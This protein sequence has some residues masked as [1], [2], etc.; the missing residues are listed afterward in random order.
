M[1]PVKGDG[2]LSRFA[3][4]LRNL[5]M[6]TGGT[7][8]L[9]EKYGAS[10]TAVYEALAGK[11]LPTSETLE[12][13]VIA[14]GAEDESI[15]W[16][17]QRLETETALEAEA[18]L[19]GE[20]KIKKTPEE[21]KFQEALTTLWGEVGHPSRNLWGDAAELSPRTVASYLDGSTLP[22]PG[23]YDQ[24]IRG[25]AALCGDDDAL[26][27]WVWEQ[28][29]TLREEHLYQ[30]RLSRKDAKE[31]ARILAV[32]MRQQTGSSRERAPYFGLDSAT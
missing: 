17:R 7:V 28:G 16:R 13:I 10:R 26:E 12:R 23:K 24:L 15:R 29:D 22:T 27:E 30:A 4:E 21:I 3:H 18:R 11:R 14:W 6:R 5:Q 31:Q 32:A 25:L 9:A 1:Q 19:R 8:P 20:I 2:A